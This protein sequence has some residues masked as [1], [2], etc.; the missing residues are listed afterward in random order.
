[1]SQLD[2]A[3]PGA[4][5]VPCRVCKG[6][7]AVRHFSGLWDVACPFCVDGIAKKVCEACGEALPLCPCFGEYRGAAEPPRGRAA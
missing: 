1:M 6:S 7:C 5:R 4:R 3:L 2:L